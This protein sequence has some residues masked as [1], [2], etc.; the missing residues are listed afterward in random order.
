MSKNGNVTPSI[1]QIQNRSL[2]EHVLEMLYAAIVN[3]ELKPGQV[4]V[5]AEL[6]GQLGV[7][8]APLREAINILHAEGLV[9]V[10]PY[11]G[12]TVKSL[13]PKDIEELYSVRTMMEGFAI[14]RIMASENKLEVV[15]ALREIC[16]AMQDAANEGDLGKLTELDRRFHSTLVMGSKNDLLMTLWK[17]VA[18]R[19]QQVMS[20]KNRRKGNLHLMA[21]NHVEIVDVIAR[22]DVE[23]AVRTI[24]RHI[25]S[26]GDLEIEGWNEAQNSSA[27]VVEKEKLVL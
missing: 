13:S 3:G 6:A 10:V 19:V 21:H 2:R 4:L 7:S 22:E 25:G 15:D 23:A 5:E 27:G 12:T 24:S 17:T 26:A 16:N 8:R 1:K 11:R 18:M 9:E 20:L 14:Q